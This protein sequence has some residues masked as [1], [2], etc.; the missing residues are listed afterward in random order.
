MLI[1]TNMTIAYKCPACGTFEFFSTSLFNVSCKKKLYLPCRCN[2]SGISI[3]GTRSGECKISVPCICCGSCHDWV[4]TKR[5][6]L[7]KGINVLYC[8][9]IGMQ[10]C[11]IGNDV[12]VRNKIDNLEKELD[13]LISMLGYDNYF[14]NTQVMIE[15]LNKVHDI[16]EQGNLICEC[17]N[18]DVELILFSDMIQLKCKKCPGSKM[19]PAGTNGDLKDILT[20][21]HLLLTHEASD[22]KM[23][24]AKSFIKTD[25]M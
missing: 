25:G 17:G 5:E 9:E 23:R 6:L 2:K 10:I 1:E 21:E 19:V 15:S 3:N 16:A 4:L 20:R 13:D 22:F 11:F 7:Q 24:K 18:S 14:K 8:P 12:D